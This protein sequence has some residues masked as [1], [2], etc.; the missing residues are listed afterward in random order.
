[1]SDKIDELISTLNRNNQE[2]ER[3]IIE[4][5]RLRSSPFDLTQ[6]ERL[7]EMF[8]FVQKYEKEFND[9]LTK[10]SEKFDGLFTNKSNLL[11]D[12]KTA[13]EKVKDLLKTEGE[14]SDN[15]IKAKEALDD[16]TDSSI[17]YHRE[18]NRYF[19]I[20]NKRIVDGITNFDDLNELFEQHTRAVRR[21]ATEISK[22]GSQIFSSINKILDPW[23]KANAEAMAYA[24]TMGISQAT[25]DKY[26]NKTVSWASENNIGLLFNKSTDE[27]IKMQGKYSDVLGRN[28]QLTSAQKKDMLAIEA[29]LG[30]DGVMDIANNLENLGYG[31][32]DSAEFIKETMDEATKTGIAA[33]K[34]TKTIRE[35]IKMAQ[36]YTFKNGLDGLSNMAKKAIELKADMSFVNSFI[37]KVSTVEGAIST[38]AQ[39]QVL[40]GNYAMGSDPL[41]MM[42]ESLND[43]EGLFDRA[44]SMA[45]GKVFYN[46]K[47]G[48]FEM[49]A[50][51]R[52]L[53]K[54]ASNA[55]GVDSSKMIDVAFRQ[56]SL[57]KIEKQAR[58]NSN[59]SSD[60]D[61]IRM[62]KN[63]ATWNN[64]NGVINVDG[65]DVKISEL[66]TN[67]KSKLE[68]MGRTDS[69]N[70][71]EMAISLRSME[72]IV[73]GI[74]KEMDNEQS[75]LVKG[76]GK[77]LDKML[78]NSENTLNSISKIGAWGKIITGSGGILAGVWTT[79]AGVW[80]MALGS[81]NIP[82]LFSRMRN[83]TGGATPTAGG[84]VSAGASSAA[85]SAAAGSAS[86]GASA[87]SGAVASASRFSKLTKLP[88]IAK[89]GGGG[90]AAGVISLGVSAINGE[91][92]KD[93]GAALG[94]AAG[95]TIGTILGGFAG[96]VGALIG[97]MLGTA[98]TQGIQ[99]AQKDYRQT[100]RD[101]ISENLSSTLP[102]IAELFNG[103][104]AL[105]G[106]YKKRQLRQLEVALSDKRLEEHEITGGLARKLRNNGDLSLLQQSG[107]NISSIRMGNG[108]LL[109]GK[110]HDKGGMPILGSN[111][112]V[113]GGE[114][115][116]N[117][118]STQHNLPLLEEI[119]KGNY[120]MTSREPLG[121]QM[122]VN[123]SN[124]F[125]DSYNNLNKN[126]NFEPISINLS[127]TIKLDGGNKQ[128][129]I[130]NDILNNPMI[131]TKLTEMISKQLNILDY[132]A[133]NK[134]RFKQKFS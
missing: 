91:L 24:K 101:E 93:T 13:K 64:G 109:N 32:S 35:N 125:S 96:P 118:Q 54:Q 79:A 122:K 41:S 52:Y 110:S 57:D 117:K 132:G 67:H 34:L 77:R 29:F 58:L 105:Q 94:N 7:E 107:V 73:S 44:V 85:G 20:L 114:Y 6:K 69:Q 2:L 25:A 70:L 26:L 11:E 43:V 5:E 86:A 134:G 9:N 31:M 39:L 22:G 76:V 18:N 84:A 74:K 16:L 46:E 95:S 119:N 40:G 19:E 49:G 100:I 8:S 128:V 59:I 36:N 103:D 62:I 115:V 28:V 4:N 17:K 83:K 92:K 133:Y 72:D 123:R 130:S 98:I 30:E 78:G 102:D 56:A 38:G 111:I 53:M 75:N 87:T 106:N 113:E 124:G 90:A 112:V 45:K 23:K 88:K 120:T 65:E 127:G 10:A 108:G 81:G 55:M 121:K 116:V 97:G 51:D 71:Q 80:K 89:I 66:T 63:L 1:M 15:Y 37:D 27:L 61:M 47:T 48:N 50:M 14:T 131:I 99:N 68:S 12:I 82:S 21:G 3:L 129:D 126:I 33:S 42:Y 60:E 104:N